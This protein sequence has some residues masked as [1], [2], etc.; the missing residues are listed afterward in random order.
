M[1][2]MTYFFVPKRWRTTWE[3]VNIAIGMRI[4]IYT[5]YKGNIC[6]HYFS[7]CYNGKSHKYT[8]KCW[9]FLHKLE[10]SYD[11]WYA[12]IFFTFTNNEKTLQFGKVNFLNWFVKANLYSKWEKVWKYR[13]Q[14]V[15]YHEKRR[16]SKIFKGFFVVSL[17]E[18]SKTR[19]NDNK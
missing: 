10:F 2:W 18:Q 7:R 4:H 3:W 13:L 12:M 5:I 16:C 14:K 1:N 9:Y 6:I 8:T 11:E 15:I 17:P 19:S